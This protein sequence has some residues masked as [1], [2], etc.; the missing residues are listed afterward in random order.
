MPE[1]VNGGDPLPGE[2]FPTGPA[3]GES[4]PDFVLPDQ[5]GHMVGSSD[6]RGDGGVLVL[7]YR[8]ADW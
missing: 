2:V 4:L 5:H 7:F 8:S 6:V 1:L 3:V